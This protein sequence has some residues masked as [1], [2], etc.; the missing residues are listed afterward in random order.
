MDS[1]QTHSSPASIRLLLI[2]P[3]FPE[4][5]WSFRWAIH[6]VMPNK[7]ALNPPLGL[8]TLAALC[9]P[10]WEVSICDENVESI[11]L[12]P[13]TDIVG[14]CGMAV[15]HPR[16]QELLAY[17]RARGYYVIAGGS[18]ASLCPEALAPYADT[19]IEGEA[20]RI[21]P[22]FC[23][24]YLAGCA[25]SHYR[26]HGT[27]DLTTS[28]VPRYD[29]LKLERY[30]TA[31]VQFSRGCPFRCEFCDIIVMFGRRPRTKSTDQIGRELDALRR[32]GARS[33]F[34]V[35]DNLIG[36][37]P[38]AKLLLRY[39]IEYQREHGHPFDL[40]TEASLNLAHDQELMDLFREAGF[41]W[42]FL[43][44]ETPDPESLRESGK[45]QNLKG[46]L[47]DA[48]RK[49]YANGIDVLGGFI[50]G[51]DHDT[52]ATFDLQYRFILDAGIQVAM[53]GLLTALPRT[54]LH[55]RLAREG[56]LN[57]DVPHGDNTD[58]RTNVIPKQMTYEEMTAG[59]KRLYLRLGEDRAIAARIDHKLRSFKPPGPRSPYSIGESVAM[60]ART[61]RFGILPGGLRRI[62]L[63]SVALLRRPIR[64]WPV[65]TTEWVRA[66][67]MRDYAQR[68]FLDCRAQTNRLA[69]CTFDFLQRRY[70]SAIADGSIFAGLDGTSLLL[71]VRGRFDPND[72]KPA[73]REIR[74]LLKRS[75]ATVTLR[76]EC[77]SQDGYALTRLLLARLGRYGDRVF[78]EAHEAVRGAIDSSVFQLR[79]GVAKE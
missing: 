79:L 31:C 3:K 19:V 33:V 29:L 30:T 77:I 14:V 12:S 64:L 42:V 25:G 32:R 68:H 9:P 17:Y 78:I 16:Q 59:Y 75:S 74:K 18:Y 13:V 70:R 56:R 46:D 7:R 55:A 20:E 2:N 41:V 57:Y 65:V 21:W 47:L 40:G 37:K 58:A 54:P 45:T 5:F 24:D 6:H 11:P 36:D 48:V 38:K 67:S 51:F 53:V 10:D 27:V 62:A 28:P 66:L 26:E 50:V 15:Q 63:F 22:A 43:G 35:D 34:F 61:L 44:I 60:F 72:L 39:L 71:A 1:V 49:L 69:E 8:A 52:V 73:M 4:S 76:I 23:R